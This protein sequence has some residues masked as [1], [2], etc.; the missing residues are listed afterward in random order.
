MRGIGAFVVALLAANAA[1]A[2]AVKV[3]G[4]GWQQLESN[5]YVVAFRPQSA[6]S[7]GQLFALVLALCAKTGALP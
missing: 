6:S 2:C 4:A 5:R 7:V 3:S 1:Q